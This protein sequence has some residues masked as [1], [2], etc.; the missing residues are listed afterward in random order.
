MR[1]LLILLM[2]THT[3]IVLAK[4]NV[5]YAIVEKAEQYFN[6]MSTLTSQLEQTNPDGSISRGILNLQRT[7]GTFQL[8]YADPAEPQIS[9]DS[10][11]III[12]YPNGGDT[13]YIPVEEM[14]VYAILSRNV[15]FSKTTTVTGTHEDNKHASITLIK[16]N[17]PNNGEITFKFL[18]AADGFKLIGW[19]VLD[20]EGKNTIVKLINTEVN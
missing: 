19:K 3:N 12:R 17:D 1:I 20:P 14:P 7:N 15:N 4:N 8:R 18:K 5:N 11:N 16:K 10:Q 9:C 6:D 13:N 2:L